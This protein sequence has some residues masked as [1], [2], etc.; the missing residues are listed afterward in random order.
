MA[1]HMTPHKQHSPGLRP[2]DVQAM[3]PKV[4]DRMTLTPTLHKSLGICTPRPREAV[5]VFVHPKHHWYMVRFDNGLRE[6]FKLPQPTVRSHWGRPRK[7]EAGLY[8]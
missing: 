2:E 6:C 7:E 4:G 5:V 1:E 3:L 8:D